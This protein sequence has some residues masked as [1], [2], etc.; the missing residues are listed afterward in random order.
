[1]MQLLCNG[2]RVDLYADEKMQF[3]KK[4]PFFAFDELS[5]ERT[6]EFKLPAT[7]NND[8]IFSVARNHAYYGE[9]MRKRF[10]MELQCGTVVKKGYLYIKAYDK[11]DY[12][13]VLVCDMLF[14]LKAFGNYEWGSVIWDN[15][16]TETQ[17]NANAASIPTVAIVKYHTE[18]VGTTIPKMPSFSIGEV[19][20]QIDTQ[21]VLPIKNITDT[22]TRYIIKGSNVALADVKENLIFTNNGDGSY[23]I[24]LSQNIIG[25][26]VIPISEIGGMQVF[27]WHI[28]YSITFPADTPQNL[29]ICRGDKRQIDPAID[30]IGSRKFKRPATA[31]GAVRYEGAPL[32]GQ[33]IVLPE[34]M[35]IGDTA[36]IL[37][38]TGAGIEYNADDPDGTHISWSEIDYG[39]DA[40]PDYNVAVRLNGYPM[41]AQSGSPFSAVFADL[42]IGTVIKAYTAATGTLIGINSDKQL[43]FYTTITPS[44]KVLQLISIEHLER[45]FADWAQKNWMQYKEV[46]WIKDWERKR[47]Y[48]T[49][50]ND[51]IETEKDLLTLDVVEGAKY[52]DNDYALAR[53]MSDSGILAEDMIAKTGS[54]EY[55][56][57]VPIQKNA[58]MQDICANSTTI[59]VN[60]R[61]SL[62]E[63][64]GMESQSTFIVENV[65]YIWVEAQWQNNIAKFTLA[66]LP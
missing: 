23:S 5:A 46:D 3:T 4:N 40:E 36:T 17:Y 24:A 42:S 15:Y 61:M 10:R 43:Q 65:R 19:L 39:I 6:A 16:Y 51:N 32:A 2:K 41:G 35:V 21:N 20:Q 49:I 31:G 48:Y 58:T 57:R 18:N 52:T 63:Y 25:T 53:N 12:K 38:L 13:A 9:A 29:C 47:N 55:M 44:D 33:T 37:L 50:D 34:E 26:D 54:L 8:A 11:K 66:K 64:S 28:G 59:K 14:D 56:Q 1:M 7:P 45:T 22:A 60:A 62:A 27:E 30:F